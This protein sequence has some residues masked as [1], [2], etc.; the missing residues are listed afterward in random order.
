MSEEWNNVEIS[1]GGGYWKKS[2]DVIERISVWKVI[3]K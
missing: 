2:V 3:K 1:K